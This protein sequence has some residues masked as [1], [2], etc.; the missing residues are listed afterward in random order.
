MKQVVQSLKTGDI[1]LTDAP[2]PSVKAGHLL[3][4]SVRSLISPG[5]ERML[6]EFGKAGYIAKARQQPDKVRQV[7]DK[8]KTD[9]LFP[10]L[11]AVFS[12]L[13][14]P[15]PLGYCNAGVVVEVGSGV[16]EFSV[17][18]RVVSNGPHAE[19]VC[20]P[21]NLCV[22][23]PDGVTDGAACFTVLGAVAL[24]G[25]R[26]TEPTLGEAIAV[27]GLGPIGLMAVQLLRSNGCRVLAVDFDSKRLELAQEFG[28]ETVDLSR[29][30]DQVAA[31]MTF[32]RGRGV[33]GVLLTASTKSDEPMHQAAAMCR[34]RG[35]IVLVGDV[36]LG[37]SRAD[38]FEKEITFQVSCSYGPGRYDSAYEERGQDYPVGFVRWT[39]QR[40]FEAVLDMLASGG[41]DVTSLIS[42][43]FPIGEAPQAYE[44]L[45]D[46]GSGLGIVLEYPEPEEQP[47]GALSRRTVRLLPA[48]A[49]SHKDAP[50]VGVIGAGN[51]AT[52][53]LLPALAK[54][55]VRLKSIADIN[56]ASCTHAGRKH[57]FEECT[58]D[59]EVLIADPE[60]DT[61]FVVT[62]HDTHARFVC[63][64]LRAGKHVFV[65]KPLAIRPDELEEIASTYEA[66]DPR[67][68]LTVGFNRR[69]APQIVKMRSLLAAAKE[70]KSFIV[71]VNAGDIPADSWLHDPA[72][73]GGRIIGEGCHFVDLLRFLAGSPIVRVQCQMM[74]P[75]PGVVVRDDKASFTLAFADG[76]FG[77]VHYLANGHRAFPK[78]RIEVFCGERILQ[79]DNFR[80]MRGYGWPGFGKMNLGRQD[81]GHKSFVN[82]FIQA[83]SQGKPSPIP[84]E[85]IV[86]VTRATF[87]IAAAAQPSESEK[88]RPRESMR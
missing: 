70:P 34:K 49:P 65:E 16:T 53:M 32:S 10:T 72:V 59:T 9:G 21:K 63:Q 66:C 46:K 52:R 5:T 88:G 48:T 74:G 58:T 15:L 43:R 84:F 80:K 20:V 85:E 38:F 78:E 11:E 79:L 54:T 82:A 73:G 37:L 12:K 30:E 64:A 25:I 28:A 76:S 40:N 50:T 31:A 86:E 61:V 69:Y 41:L 81:K 68:I 87:D 47:E 51:Y 60:I 2:C 55:G 8:I 62:R 44:V 56:S 18:D 33:D 29:E 39:E 67:P 83:V 17:G 3:I 36:G 22:S 14:T 23:I 35:R 7:L 75:A 27:V 77:T 13:D 71:T 45:E 6:M 26:L 4:R 19:M 1:E 57:G 42:H 24:Q